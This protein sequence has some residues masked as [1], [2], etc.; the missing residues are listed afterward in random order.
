MAQGFTSFVVSV[1][2]N[3][4]IAAAVFIFFGVFRKSKF[5]SKYYAPRRY[6]AR[7][8]TCLL[9]VCLALANLSTFG[10]TMLLLDQGISDHLYGFSAMLLAAAALCC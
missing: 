8:A 10:L 1:A 7:P 9:G 3:F 6:A 2:I 4:A 5:V